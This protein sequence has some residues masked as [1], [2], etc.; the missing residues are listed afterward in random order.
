MKL[1]KLKSILKF[2][3]DF[4]DKE[5][6]A[7]FY[8]EIDDILPKYA[9]NIDVVS[10]DTNYITCDFYKFIFKHKDEITN[11]IKIAY[12]DEYVVN[13]LIDIFVNHDADC[14]AYFIE[15]DMDNFLRGDY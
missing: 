4:A 7:T 13:S 14:I 10:I 5:I 8:T 9:D 15:H 6:D 3:P 2:N 1:S 11:Y 12:Y